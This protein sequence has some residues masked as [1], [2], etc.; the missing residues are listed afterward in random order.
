MAFP[1]SYRLGFYDKL[2]R[3]GIR[4]WAEEGPSAPRRLAAVEYALRRNGCM[5]LPT[6]WDSEAKSPEFQAADPLIRGGLRGA[7]LLIPTIA[8]G[9]ATTSGREEMD[10]D[11]KKDAPAR[12]QDVPS[13][14]SLGVEVRAN[15]GPLLLN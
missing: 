12:R 8:Q 2:K 13:Y 11:T 7:P 4:L 6:V 10:T 14:S 1:G 15:D 9:S 5:P 3:A